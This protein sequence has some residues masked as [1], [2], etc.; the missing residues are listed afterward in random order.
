MRKTDPFF[1]IAALLICTAVHANAQ[2]EHKAPPILEH[3]VPSP[4]HSIFPSENPIH[5]AIKNR[6]AIFMPFLS[7]GSLRIAE[8][9]T[10]PGQNGIG[11]DVYKRQL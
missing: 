7:T 11:P 6:N 4:V 8:A 2:S 1:T 5:L 9:C 10:L 3:M